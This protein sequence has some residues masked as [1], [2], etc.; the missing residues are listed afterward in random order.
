MRVRQLVQSL[1]LGKVARGARELLLALAGGGG[2]HNDKRRAEAVRLGWVRTRN[3]ALAHEPVHGGV[4]A[5]LVVGVHVTRLHLRDDGLALGAAVHALLAQ[6]SRLRIGSRTYQLPFAQTVRT[7]AL[8]H[9][10]FAVAHIA[11]R[12]VTVVPIMSER[13]LRPYACS[14]CLCAAGGIRHHAIVLLTVRFD[15]GIAV[16]KHLQ[17]GGLATFVIEAVGGDGLCSGIAQLLIPLIRQVLAAGS[18]GEDCIA[19]DTF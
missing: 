6:Q 17:A 9:L 1:D 14:P 18:H 5:R 10:A 3:A 12:A 13:M 8:R 4:T 15:A 19:V 7:C 2:L 16:N 11:M